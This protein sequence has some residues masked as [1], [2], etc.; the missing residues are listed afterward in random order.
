MADQA[1]TLN[2]NSAGTTL[3]VG[4]IELNYNDSLTLTIGT[5]FPNPA[6]TAITQVQFY[7]VEGGGKGSTPKGSWTINGPNSVPAGVEVTATPSGGGVILKDVDDGANDGD[8]YYNVVATDST[9]RATYPA[10]P[11]L[12]LRKK[13]NTGGN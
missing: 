5:G 11:E 4:K 2:T 3:S 10:D 8:Y 12:I 7:N 13:Q 1:G 6:N 9:T